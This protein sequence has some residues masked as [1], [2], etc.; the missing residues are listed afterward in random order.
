MRE[1]ERT[2]D[3]SE[4]DNSPDFKTT[5]FVALEQDLEPRPLIAGILTF[6]IPPKASAHS[7]D[8]A[9]V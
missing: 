8:D 9:S 1:V 7:Y 4:A 5:V 3:K 6:L 2:L